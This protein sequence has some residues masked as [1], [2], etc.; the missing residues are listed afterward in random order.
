[1]QAPGTHTLTSKFKKNF[2]KLEISVL[3][4]YFIVLAE[5]VRFLFLHGPGKKSVCSHSFIYLF[6]EHF[7]GMLD[8][9]GPKYSMRTIY[10]TTVAFIHHFF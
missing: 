2:Q 6:N 8:L 3:V 9:F 10:N 1:M 5:M 7:Y 4:L